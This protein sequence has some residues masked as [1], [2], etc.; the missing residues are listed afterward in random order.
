MSK[1]STVKNNYPFFWLDELTE[2]KLNPDKTAVNEFTADE[3]QTIRDQLPGKLNR[4]I[5]H[6]KTQAFCLYSS[7]H[8]KV[9]AGHY[10]QAIRQLQRQT[11]INLAQYSPDGP[12]RETGQTLLNGLNE[13][14]QKIHQRYNGYLA[15]SA[16][17]EPETQALFKVLCRLSVDQIA[18][19]LKAA[20]EIQLLVSR[21]LS[22]VLRRI[23]PFLS[24]E[25][26]QNFSWKSARS[27]TYKMEAS[28][29]T[30][31]IQ[32]LEALIHKIQEY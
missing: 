4:I 30:V 26:L 12:L 8:I 22:L 29:K 27:S 14:Y 1:R 5:N 25:R 15:D 3:L 20:D 13:L 21:S 18:I 17:E 2:V 32:A 11:Q 31:A 24:T 6:L 10:D 16:V 28:D 7:D 23:I 19:I 9:V